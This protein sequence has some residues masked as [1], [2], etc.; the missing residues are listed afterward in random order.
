MKKTR[1]TLSVL[2][3]ISLL[4]L[5]NMALANRPDAFAACL[6]RTESDRS[7]CQSGCGMILQSS[8]DETIQTIDAKASALRNKLSQGRAPACSDLARQY[9]GAALNLDSNLSSNA[10]SQPGWLS[11]ELSLLFAQ[12][13]L[14]VI[15]LIDKTCK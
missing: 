10:A 6:K 15:Q 13:R 8:Y 14:E 1:S 7:N 2:L 4:L 9:A 5:S 12:Q 11:A 3:A